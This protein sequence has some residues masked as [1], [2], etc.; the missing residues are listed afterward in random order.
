MDEGP[1]HVQPDPGPGHLCG[2]LGAPVEQAKGIGAR[3][4]RKARTAVKDR[5][6]DARLIAGEQHVHGLADGAVLGGV[7][8]QVAQDLHRKAIVRSDGRQVD[9]RQ[10]LH[11][12]SRPASLFGAT[13]RTGEAL[14]E[15]GF[16]GR[17]RQTTLQASDRQ[18]VL[19]E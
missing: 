14:E 2:D 15:D 12:S 7:G 11:M 4:G 9:I 10:D 18:E 17:L 3:L 5:H 8:D 6:L 19:D 1:R 13:C 16:A